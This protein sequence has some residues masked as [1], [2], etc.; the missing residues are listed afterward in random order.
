MTLI[1]IL[2]TLLVCSS[3]IAFAADE[4]SKPIEVSAYEECAV[5]VFAQS[6]KLSDVYAECEAEMEAFVALHDGKV[7]EKI[8]HRAQAETQRKMR[9]RQMEKNRQQRKD[10]E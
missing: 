2:I 10:G 4:P 7:Q 8:R 1:R 6:D 9:A 5:R 3:P